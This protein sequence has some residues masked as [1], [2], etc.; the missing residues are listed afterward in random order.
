MT[1][2]RSLTLA[3]L[4]SATFACSSWA[5]TQRFGEPPNDLPP[6][7]RAYREFL[8]RQ[9]IHE[10]LCPDGFPALDGQWRILVRNTP[11]APRDEIVFRG[12]QFTEF[13]AHEQDTKKEYGILRGWYACVD[14]NKILFFVES[15]EPDGA[16]DNA[17][18]DAYPCQLYWNPIETNDTFSLLCSFDWNPAES[19]GY[20]FQRVH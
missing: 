13:K 2:A 4:C 1:F 20:S 7:S 17:A 11:D 9:V 15:V 5:T 12:R 8:L 10:N 3:L 14:G 18:G 16:F 6:Q 19:A